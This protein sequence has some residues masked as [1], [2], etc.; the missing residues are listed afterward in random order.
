[1]SGYKCIK[2]SEQKWSIEFNYIFRLF[3]GPKIPKKKCHFPPNQF[4]KGPL[5]PPVGEIVR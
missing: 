5:E 3:T 1:M 2:L 4:H